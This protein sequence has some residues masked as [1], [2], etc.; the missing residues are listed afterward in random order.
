MKK[1]ALELF[2]LLVVMSEQGFHQTIWNFMGV[3]KKAVM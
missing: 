3:E 1:N 2:S